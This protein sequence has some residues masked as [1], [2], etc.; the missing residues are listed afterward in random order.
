MEIKNFTITLQPIQI[1]VKWV[2]VFAFR[3][4]DNGL[5]HQERVGQLAK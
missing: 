1:S 2:M 4:D 5:N 3:A